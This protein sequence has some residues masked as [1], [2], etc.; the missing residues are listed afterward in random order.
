MLLSLRLVVIHKELLLLIRSEVF[1]LLTFLILLLILHS[2]RNFTGTWNF[3]VQFEIMDHV[4]LVVGARVRR[5]LSFWS[6]LRWLTWARWS[7]FVNESVIVPSLDFTWLFDLAN[8]NKGIVHC[9][10]DS[11]WLSLFYFHAISDLREARS[12][13]IVST[14]VVIFLFINLFEHIDFDFLFDAIF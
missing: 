11:D 7:K 4:L 5:W 1:G 12:V 10:I 3:D 2:S 13:S 14:K 9:S 8:L 6:C